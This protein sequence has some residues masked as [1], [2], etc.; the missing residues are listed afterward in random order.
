MS[1]VNVYSGGLVV[2]DTL[3]P[4]D[5]QIPMIHVPY[6]FTSSDRHISHIFIHLDI[7]VF[8]LPFYFLIDHHITNDPSHF[9]L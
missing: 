3:S 2:S 7:D 9:N 4:T 6:N 1:F 5:N 8:V